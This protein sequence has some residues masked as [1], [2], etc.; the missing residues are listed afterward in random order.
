[1]KEENIKRKTSKVMSKF[2]ISKHK[3]RGFRL[4]LQ[5]MF[6]HKVVDGNFGLP[7]PSV[8]SDNPDTRYMKISL[9]FLTIS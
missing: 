2:E 1:M 9:N 3:G 5:R 4:L 7:F 6:V 8:L